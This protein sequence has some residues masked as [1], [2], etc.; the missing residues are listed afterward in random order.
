MKTPIATKETRRLK[1]KTLPLSTKTY[2]KNT[3]QPSDTQTSCTWSVLQSCLQIRGGGRRFHSRETTGT[4]DWL[5]KFQYRCWSGF[6]STFVPANHNLEYEDPKNPQFSDDTSPINTAPH[7]EMEPPAY[8]C[9]LV[10]YL[11]DEVS[12]SIQKPC[13]ETLYN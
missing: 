8:F 6:I 3:T 12:K 5:I 9:S 10:K 4:I 13:G 11:A 1:S 2:K 7:E